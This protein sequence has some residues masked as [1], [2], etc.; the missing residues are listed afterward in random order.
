ML[1]EGLERI[2]MEPFAPMWH[3]VHVNVAV[4][5]AKAMPALGAVIKVWIKEKVLVPP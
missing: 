3:D 5:V 2:E 1:L 4:F